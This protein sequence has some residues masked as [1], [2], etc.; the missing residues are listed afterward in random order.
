MY[1][2]KTGKVIEA[3]GGY[4]EFSDRSY[5]DY[6]GGTAL[7]RYFREMLREAMEADG[8]DVY[9]WEWWHFDF[10]DWKAYPILNSTFEELE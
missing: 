2:L 1:D 8:F 10:K 3:V 5:P 4:D 7:Q 9:Q 6:P